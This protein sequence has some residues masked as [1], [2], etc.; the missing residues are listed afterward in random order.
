MC[1]EG[2]RTGTCASSGGEGTVGEGADYG[3]GE[4]GVHA[5][6]EG[7][8]L[9]EVGGGAAWE[10]EGEGEEEDGEKVEEQHLPLVGMMLPGDE[11]C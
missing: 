5:G 6:L 8:I 11:L 1:V 4:P 3:H 7:R 2:R 9:E 10:G